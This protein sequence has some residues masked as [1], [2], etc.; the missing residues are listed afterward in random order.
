MLDAIEDILKLNEWFG[1]VHS[2]QSML[3]TFER[4]GGLDFLEELQKHPHLDI[5]NRC[6]DILTRFFEKAD[7]MEVSG[8]QNFNS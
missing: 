2:D 4:L 7:S 6:E 3:L 1:W 5:Y 8:A